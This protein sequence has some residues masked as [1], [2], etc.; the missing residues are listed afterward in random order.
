MHHSE[1]LKSGLLIFLTLSTLTAADLFRGMT[2]D[3]ILTR[4]LPL[5]YGALLEEAYGIPRTQM[6]LERG[7]YLIIVPDNL[8]NY[9]T[10]PY[11]FVAF[12]KSQGFKT[13]VKTLTEF[14]STAEDI[15]ANILQYINDDPMLEYILLI[16]DVDGVSAMP[17]FYYGPENDATD[18]KYTH[19]LGDDS[20]PDCFIGRFSVDS[21]TELVVIINKTIN[22][23][24]DPV[25]SSG[26]LDNALIVAGN[27][28]NTIPIPITPKWTSYWL[29]DELLDWG[30]ES[31]DTVF[32]P[33]TQQGAAMIQ[34][35]INDGVGIVNYR[36]WGD[37][38]G[39]HYPE[40]HVADVAGL[41]N[42]NLTPV[43]TSF[44]CN[45]A[46]F[47][48]N[49]DPCLGE[50]LVRAGS[51]TVASGAVAVV[52]PSDLH[53][54][55]KFNNV[56]NTYMYDAMLDHGVRELAPAMLAGQ[57]GLQTEFPQLDG[58]GEGQEFYLH[59]YNILG[60]PSLNMHLLTPAEFTLTV[61]PI[62]AADGM[63]DVIVTTGNDVAVADAVVAV[64]Q[65]GILVDRGITDQ[66]GQVII[67]GAGLEGTLDLY[68]NKSGYAQ[69][70]ETLTVEAAT[71]PM[72]I[73]DF[74]ITD[75]SDQELTSLFPGNLVKVLP[76]LM[77]TGTTA[78]PAGSGSITAGNGLQVVQSD[79]TYPAVN[80]GEVADATPVSVRLR[81]FGPAANWVIN[82]SDNE[83]ALGSIALT[84]S[85][86]VFAVEPLT[87]AL[88]P[89]T[90][91]SG[92]LN[93]TNFSAA[94]YSGLQGE[95][96][97]LTDSLTVTSGQSP[98]FSLAAWGTTAND[99]AFS[100]I[101]GNVSPGSALTVRLHIF[102]DTVK[103]YSTDLA[104]AAVPA[105]ATD[106]VAPDDYGYWAYDNADAG[107][108]QAPTYDWVELSDNSQASLHRLDDDDHVDLALP[109]NFRYY[110]QD[111]DQVTVSSNGWI[112][113]VPCMI[114][115]FWNFSIPMALGP[116]A[117]IA[118]FWD[119]LEV[120]G[121]DSIRVYTWHDE[122]NGRFI[123]EWDRALN[124]YNE[125]TEETF[126]IIL[127]DQQSM[128]TASGD[129]VIELHY[130]A[131]DDVD[132]TKNYSTVGIESAD[133]NSGVQYVFNNRYAPGASALNGGLAIRFT[134][135]APAHYVPSLA[136][137]EIV[138]SGEFRLLPA[139]PNPFNPS[140]RIQFNLPA[141]ER[142]SVA[143]YDLRGR[144]IVKLAD[145]RFTGGRHILTWHGLDRYDRP[146]ASGTY[147][148]VVSHRGGRSVSKLLLLK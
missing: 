63:I 41:A 103:I 32:Y 94:E 21:I 129:G 73:S 124:G 88:V 121:T 105:T 100:G 51:P 4:T 43:F 126:E 64:L 31:V 14:G 2:R 130:L 23:H 85:R 148:A 52:G 30:Y 140:T 123:I 98:Q 53:T 116:A 68:V 134:T 45:S 86:P 71:R 33:P 146:V 95:L 74:N 8:Q 119:D 15:K 91:F 5:S 120:V 40:F 147:F 59:V 112:S 139:F 102:Q 111:Y 57:L 109:F 56:I 79:F 127:Y 44:V 46:D 50:A 58:P 16:G 84:V 36:G 135:E 138:P 67:H 42:G 82:L 76:R 61:A 110:G 80:P 141:T 24:R 13:I 113:F 145:R 22:Y 49:V 90:S 27:Y 99:G 136:V 37:A 96:T 89:G 81:A 18:Q 62:S 107:F 106:P 137:D 87:A 34:S 12:K 104:L 143:I 17:S 114:D 11:D 128:P 54:S 3:Q 6:N 55:T 131:I 97:S 70:Y 78:L 65:D 66:N 117:Q 77:N 115:Y 72:I 19:L 20:I 133:Q 26:W 132:A 75:F 29:R 101:T 35:A 142:I 48:N 108:T 125:T 38:N 28:S 47:A 92:S 118:A 93:L 25:N 1:K 39:W 83:G 144:E 60:D 122:T 9:L 7:T 69:G 10:T